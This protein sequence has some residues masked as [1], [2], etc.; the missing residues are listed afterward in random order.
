MA[1]KWS[2]RERFKDDKDGVVLNFSGWKEEVIMMTRKFGLYL[3]A[4]ATAILTFAV[5]DDANAW[6]RR[7]GSCGSNGGYSSNGGS[8]GSFGG[9]GWRRRGGSWGSNGG[10]G[11]YGSNGGHYVSN[12]SCGS[13]GGYSSHSSS[14]HEGEVIY[15]ESEGSVEHEARYHERSESTFDSRDTTRPMPAP[16]VVP[17]GEEET[18]R[19]SREADRQADEGQTEQGQAEQARQEQQGQP[20][21]DQPE[22]QS[23][24]E[25]PST[26]SSLEP[27]TEPGQGIQEGQQN[28]G[29][30]QP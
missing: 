10:N 12:G 9:R 14:H 3:V 4:A 8:F 24:P 15:E 17:E 29:N 22:T 5:A 19:E 30:P 25:Q 27:P 6:G 1:A 7:N 26:D 28:P 2:T 20:A 18:T 16:V 21:Q 23:A 11:S 13:H